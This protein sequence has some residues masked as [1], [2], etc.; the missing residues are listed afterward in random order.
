MFQKKKDEI[1]SSMSNAFGIFDDN[2]ITGFDKHS[3]DHDEM[4]DNILWICRQ[5]NLK[6]NQD[7]CLFR[8]MNF[9][10]FGEIISQ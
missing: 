4:L 5:S 10:F 2:L 7:K 6:W 8:C 3:R 1:I 9:P